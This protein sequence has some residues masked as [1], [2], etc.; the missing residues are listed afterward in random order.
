MLGTCIDELL[1]EYVDAQISAGRAENKLEGL[2]ER[3]R[4]LVANQSSE[5][6]AGSTPAPSAITARPSP[7]E[8]PE[9]VH[10]R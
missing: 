3:R 10:V 7:V 6:L 5:S 8:I 4:Q 1:A 9:H 2:A